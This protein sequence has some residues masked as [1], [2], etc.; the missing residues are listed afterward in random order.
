MLNTADQE[1]FLF[2]SFNFEMVERMGTDTQSSQVVVKCNH[3]L[4]KKVFR[5]RVENTGCGRILVNG[6]TW[7]KLGFETR[8]P[9]S[10]P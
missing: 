7:L 1:E 6:K 9:F 5:R 10:L 2:V 3:C 8:H 4:Q